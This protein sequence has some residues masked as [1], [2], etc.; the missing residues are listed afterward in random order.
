M[1][2]NENEISKWVDRKA[3]DYMCSYC[4]QEFVSDKSFSAINHKN[5]HRENKE[6]AR[7]IK[8]KKTKY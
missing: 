6:K 4:G 5:K 8:Y 1:K 3:K 2:F 7:F